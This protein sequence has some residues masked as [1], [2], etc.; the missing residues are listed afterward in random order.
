MSLAEDKV[1][2]AMRKWAPGPGGWWGGTTSP[3][4]THIKRG[5]S[6][7][8]CVLATRA[9]KGEEKTV[10]GKMKHRQAATER[11]A[12]RTLARR[13][14]SGRDQTLTPGKTRQGGNGEY[15]KSDFG[16]GG[17]LEEVQLRQRTYVRDTGVGPGS[18]GEEAS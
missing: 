15:T 2:E 17:S 5:G 13:Q 6:R 8:H 11:T 14:D 3:G 4:E 7:G 18:K 9:R 1:Q 10:Q 16:C 12:S